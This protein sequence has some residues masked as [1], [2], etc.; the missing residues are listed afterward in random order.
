MN[1]LGR[2]TMIPDTRLL[3][4]WTATALAGGALDLLWRSLVSVP[5]HAGAD[6]L[7]TPLFHGVLAL[8]LVVFAVAPYGEP[9]AWRRALPL[10]AAIGAVTFAGLALRNPV[11]S[12]M[13]SVLMVSIDIAWGALA[14]ALGAAA[15]KAWLGRLIAADVYAWSLSA[16]K[17]PAAANGRKPGP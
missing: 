2:A 4:T 8:A 15:G 10:A 3:Q 5:P 9:N 7:L 14:G 12:E 6:P 11:D 17:A 16:P 13:R 1:A